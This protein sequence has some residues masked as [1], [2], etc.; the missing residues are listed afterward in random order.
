M[1]I[2]NVR[3]LILS[4]VKYKFKALNYQLCGHKNGVPLMNINYE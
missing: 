1:K 3:T 4:E 2:D